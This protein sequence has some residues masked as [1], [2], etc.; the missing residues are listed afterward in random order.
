MPRAVLTLGA[1]CGCA[2]SEINQH[3]TSNP[4][5]A[6][7]TKLWNFKNGACPVSFYP[8]NDGSLCKS[9]LERHGGPSYASYFL[10]FVA[11]AAA[12][13]GFTFL[14]WKVTGADW[15][16]DCQSG[17][18]CIVHFGRVDSGRHAADAWFEMVDRRLEEDAGS[19]HLD[20]ATAEIVRGDEV[21]V[22]L[23]SKKKKKKVVGTTQGTVMSVNGDS[24]RVSVHGKAGTKKIPLS[25]LE[26]MQTTVL[27]PG[28]SRPALCFCLSDEWCSATTFVGD[29][30]RILCARS[31]VDL[32]VGAIAEMPDPRRQALTAGCGW[33]L[34]GDVVATTDGHRW[35]VN[36]LKVPT[37]NLLVVDEQGK[38]QSADDASD[39]LGQMEDFLTSQRADSGLTTAANAE[40]ALD[41]VELSKDIRASIATAKE[42]VAK[43]KQMGYI[44]TSCLPHPRLFLTLVL[45]GISKLRCIRTGVCTQKPFQDRDRA[46]A[47]VPARAIVL[48]GLAGDSED[49]RK[50]HAG[51]DNL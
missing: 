51:S 14:A 46:A 37:E 6:E 13:F 20:H 3:E 26:M 12:V 19:V 50:N 40:F 2:R 17:E 48:A 49:L 32:A 45:R 18:S 41:N 44:P 5:L 23:S 8:S 21:V 7:F 16:P 29:V 35:L 33:V 25:D 39:L 11:L 15:S 47:A 4:G 27:E 10:S 34:C 9:C 38:A 22:S 30:T 42:A 43:A 31:G 36:V 1:R 24:A 28:A